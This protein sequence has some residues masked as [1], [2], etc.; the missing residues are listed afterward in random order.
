MKRWD[1][2]YT[3]P[4]LAAAVVLCGVLATV[5]TVVGLRAGQGDSARRVMD[6]RADMALAAVRSETDRYRTL[7]ETV[8][9]GLAT[10]E[11]ITW[12]DFDQ[13]TSPLETAGLLGAVAVAYVVP[14]TTA[15]VPAAQQRWRAAGSNG[16][17]LSPGPGPD[18]H[19]FP[20]FARSLDDRD[21]PGGADLATVAQPAAAL[22]TARQTSGVTVSD[23]YVL[24][25]DRN[26]PAGER[27]QSFV[28]AAP[29]L[30]RAND[31]VF[32]GWVVLGLRGGDFLSGVLATFSQ[33]QLDGSLV[34]VN[35]D[36]SRAEV[37]QLHVPGE[38]DL[39]RPMTIR[40][41]DHVWELGLRADSDR[42]PGAGGHLW[43]IV[44]A[45]GLILTGLLAWL[46]FVLATG[47]TRA[48]DRVLEA[49]AELRDAEA[50]SRRQAGLL[51]AI[52][53]TIGDGV[54][55]V[56]ADGRVLME[57][58]AAKRLMGVAEASHDP[59]DWQRHYGAF[60]PDGVTPMPLEEMPLIRAMRG[61]CATGE[62]LLRNAG[63]PDGVLL[64]VDARPLDP[65][66]G[67]RGAVAVTRD[68]TD[69][70]Q[71]E[72][73]L[74]IFAGVVA[75]DLKSPLAI[76]RGHC[77][78]AIDDPGDEIAVQ[79]A[80]D[81]IMRAVDRMDALIETLLAY[82]TA[83]DAPLSIVDLP[84]E[85]LVREVLQERA[86]GL[87]GTGG[88]APQWSVGPLPTVRADPAMLRHVLDNLIGNAFKYV[89]PG[90]V[91]R[92]DVT[93]TEAGP[94]CTRIRVADAGIG[95]PEPDKARVFDSF[96]RAPGSA[97]YAGTGLGL[98]ICR[99]VVERHGG[100][101][102]VEDNPGGGTRFH[103]T[104]PAAI[105]QEEPEMRHI[106]TEPAE[107]EDARV[108]AALD[109]ALAER[110][111]MLDSRL[112]GLTALPAAEPSAHDP[113]AARLR[114]PVPDHQH[115]D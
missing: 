7:L 63:R 17:T 60:R 79:L 52:M 94:G 53:A 42:L 57:N 72:K 41:A 39:T 105:N 71:Y 35:S 56:D 38:P 24:L 51:G 108:R 109:R 15:D 28:F 37:A 21:N 54:S 114:A 115:Q 80:L 73:D 27:Q 6:Q 77:E 44:L 68:V 8:A 64:G 18:E 99:R 19:Y 97:G 2:R 102:G 46:V 88:P 98:A 47:R 67:L 101:I 40:V 103:F 86:A 81:R 93:A 4:V 85:P 25:R 96:H 84:L 14:V 82:S 107:E 62:M 95:I 10:D 113:A 59:Q 66:G 50:E 92:A 55:V 49:T 87:R 36:G 70:R 48:R 100:E 58:P 20:V 90:T 16:L 61:E 5:L 111:A 89:R 91:P 31:P 104:L 74:A 33:G 110:A 34:A 13:A 12:A 112:P 9:A 75:H 22:K 32:R 69:L 1:A 76:A 3:G 29:V 106:P 11:Q 43:V 26:R 65:S 45:G 23:T 78:L 83:R 30:T